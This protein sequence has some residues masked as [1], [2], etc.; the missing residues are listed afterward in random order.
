MLKKKC[1]T[2][3]A[4]TI[5]LAQQMIQLAQKGKQNHI[6]KGWWHLLRGELK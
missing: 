5:K 3:I 2:N 6:E 1:D 4:S